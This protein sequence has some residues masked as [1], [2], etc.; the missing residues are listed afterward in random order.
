VVIRGLSEVVS[1]VER[2]A[3]EA[4][5]QFCLQHVAALVI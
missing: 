4:D 3:L 2:N 1:E 5:G